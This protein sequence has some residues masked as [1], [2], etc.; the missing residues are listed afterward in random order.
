MQVINNIIQDMSI[1]S[2]NSKNDTSRPVNDWDSVDL[3]QPQ[4][5]SQ[6]VSIDQVDQQVSQSQ[7]ILPH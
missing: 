7:I 1:P 2:K 3:R 4:E 5:S 6:S